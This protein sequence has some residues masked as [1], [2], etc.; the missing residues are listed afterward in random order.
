MVK[1]LFDF[2]YEMNSYLRGKLVLEISNSRLH[3]ESINLSGS[4]LL[5]LQQM[6]TAVDTFVNSALHDLFTPLKKTIIL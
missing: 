5:D 2:I 6:P 1:E 3:E 4:K